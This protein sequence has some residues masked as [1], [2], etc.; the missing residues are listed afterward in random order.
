MSTEFKR[1][2]QRRGSKL[3]L[4]SIAVDGELSITT[5]TIEIYY[6]ARGN[7]IKILDVNSFVDTLD[8]PSDRIP[9]SVAQVANVNDSVEELKLYIEDDIK[10][11][12]DS[13][14]DVL[15][16]K[17]VIPPEDLTLMWFDTN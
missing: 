5:D 15:I 11:A 2:L 9:A 12:I 4:P 7:H 14:Q 8:N 17:G 1:M 3:N 16:V 13:K 10:K 6:G